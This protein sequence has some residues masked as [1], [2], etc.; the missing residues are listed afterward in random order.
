MDRGDH[1]SSTMIAAEGHFVPVPNKTV[2]PSPPLHRPPSVSRPWTSADHADSA[3]RADAASPGMSISSGTAEHVSGNQ[4]PTPF[5]P[6]S[7]H[8]TDPPRLLPDTM[9]RPFHCA[10]CNVEF[11]RSDVRERHMKRFHPEEG[12]AGAVSSSSSLSLPQLSSSAAE[13]RHRP[14][15]RER[16]RSKLACDQCRKRKLKCN[17]TRPC[18]SCRTKMLL[19][20]IS[21]S[22][23][24]AGR[25]PNRVSVSSVA[26]PVQVPVPVPL[27]QEAT[28]STLSSSLAGPW[29]PGGLEPSPLDTPGSFMPRIADGS[30]LGIADVTPR[31]PSVVGISPTGMSQGVAEIVNSTET[32]IPCDPYPL[33]QIWQEVHMMDELLPQVVSLT[34]YRCSCFSHA[35]FVCVVFG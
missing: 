24:P 21:G 1:D 33:D 19:C 26:A 6:A 25:P 2:M 9:G 27:E 30:V 31:L 15:E 17:N 11:A 4:P 20:T 7:I 34:C 8:G 23:R 28:A 22:S 13:K 32:T 16:E 3:R 10:H 12:G 29:A 35:D 5:S 14:H 18:D